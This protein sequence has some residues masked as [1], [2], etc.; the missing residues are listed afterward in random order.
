M[1]DLRNLLLAIHFEALSRVPH[2]SRS[3]L[4]TK[5]QYEREYAI[6]MLEGY[7]QLKKAGWIQTPEN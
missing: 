4:S 6:G 2:E 3:S 5:F 1:N 7:E